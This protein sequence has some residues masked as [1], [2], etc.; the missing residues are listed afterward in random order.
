MS[1]LLSTSGL[2]KDRIYCQVH[3]KKTKYDGFRSRQEY[4]SINRQIIKYSFLLE[5][6]GNFYRYIIYNPKNLDQLIYTIQ[7]LEDWEPIKNSK[8]MPIHSAF[9]NFVNH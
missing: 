8:S 3:V 9:R 6:D 2:L 5:R 1:A 7:S 4:C